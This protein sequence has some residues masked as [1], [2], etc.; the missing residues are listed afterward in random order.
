M[1]YVCAHCGTIGETKDDE[2]FIFSVEN[3]P[4]FV[5]EGGNWYVSITCKLCMFEIG[6]HVNDADDLM[7]FVRHSNLLTADVVSKYKQ[8]QNGMNKQVQDA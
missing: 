6:G 1:E 2:D 5:R 3:T 7:E 4:E 8:N